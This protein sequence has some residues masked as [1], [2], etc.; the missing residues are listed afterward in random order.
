MALQGQHALRIAGLLAGMVAPLYAGGFLPPAEGPVPF[1]RDQIPL[2]AD[3]MAELSMKL[4]VIT[5][6]FTAAK[7]TEWRGVAQTLALAMA[8]DPANPR[9]RKLLEDCQ[10]GWHKGSGDATMLG[11]AR[12]RI[13]YYVAWLKTPQAGGDGQELAACLEDIL[14]LSD[15]NHPETKEQGKWAGWVPDLSAYEAQVAKHGNPPLPRGSAPQSQILLSKAE[16]HTLLWRKSTK[17]ESSS[18]VLAPAPLQMT[19]I[20]TNEDSGWKPPL[21]IA[22]GSAADAL[23]FTQTNTLL[24]NLLKQQH[25]NLPAGYKITITCKELEQSVQ[26]RKRQSLSAAAAVLAS[27][28]VTGR[29]P[30][31]II[32]GQVDDSGTFKLPTGFW[33]QIMALG[34]GNGQ[35]L[36]LPTAAAAS[37]P[38]ILAMEKPGFFLE[39]E[40]LLAANF[41]QL[42][43]LTAKTPD[44][45]LAKSSAQFRAIRDKI[46]SQEIHQYIANRFVRQRLAD[47]RQAT[48]GH[49]SAT[50]LLVQASGN[51][52]VAVTRPVLAAELRRAIEPMDWLVKTAGLV[53]APWSN[54]GTGTTTAFT[55]AD[56]VKLIPTL[57][58]C[59]SRI[60]ALERYAD[61]NDRELVERTRKDLSS[62][63]SLD[64]AVR[65]RG[66]SYQ[67]TAAIH[68]ACGEFL[69]TH[70]QLSEHLTHVAGEP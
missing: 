16:V 67:V 13:S 52:P 58:L 40:V 35:R 18:W 60:D 69:N 55:T 34:K 31:A 30:E 42:L 43:D 5:R 17:D 51:R 7:P 20:K 57:D 22:L 68:T 9:P 32:I 48:P 59:R 47:I 37:V 50:M 1:R 33:E 53:Y 54:G 11:L 27:A 66:A 3:A 23:A 6:G 46:G 26:S 62:I 8:L 61:K 10:Q 64:K 45:T 49:F 70:K 63:R 38:S 12:D 28:A 15:P 56:Q 19:V 24:L 21:A 44:E 36:V 65:T 41:Q 29:E 25:D 14:V 39:Y 4:G 2:E